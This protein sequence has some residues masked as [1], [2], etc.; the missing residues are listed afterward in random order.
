METN[1]HSSGNCRGRAEEI[2]L[3]ITNYH[4]GL[5]QCVK[6]IKTEVIAGLW[7]HVKKD[8]LKMSI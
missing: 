6:T 1:V 7:N 3:S 8:F 2:G 5:G 4:N